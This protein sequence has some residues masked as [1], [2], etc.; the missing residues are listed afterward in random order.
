MGGNEYLAD[1]LAVTATAANVAHHAR[2]VRDKNYAYTTQGKGAPVT[3][4]LGSVRLPGP[5]LP[6]SLGAAWQRTGRGLVIE[7]GAEEVADLGA[8]GHDT[9][10]SVAPEGGVTRRS[11][12]CRR[13]PVARSIRARLSRDLTVPSGVLVSSESSL[14]VRPSL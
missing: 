10:P 7:D 1:I 14:W 6:W 11:W 13:T 9:V 8:G 4:A 2:I 12:V 3:A 5:G